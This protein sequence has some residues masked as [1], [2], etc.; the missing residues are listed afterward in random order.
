MISHRHRCLYVKAPKCASTSILQWFLAHGAGR[1]T[2]RPSWYPGPLEHRI[3]PAAEALALYPD[4]VLFTFLRDPC[5]RF[6]STW[7]HA[8]RLVADGAPRQ[9]RGYGSLHDFARLCAELLAETR[10]LWGA[11]ALNFRAEHGRRRYGPHGIE[12]RH[13]YF[14]PCHAR[15]QVDFLP[16]G[17]PPSLF[18][19][20][21]KRPA[22]PAFTGRV[23][24]LDKDFTRLCARLGLAGP[25]LPRENATQRDAEPRMDATTRR[26]VE[27]LYAEDY[28]LLAA[29]PPAPGDAA[30]PRPAGMKAR[31]GRARLGLGAAEIALEAR[32]ARC[33][34]LRRALAPLS[35]LRRSRA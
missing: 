33:A 17:D 26:L 10:G 25:A 19:V 18:G 22:A 6:F 30:A 31:L 27:E 5:A 14:L 28:A 24:T 11:E 16:G 29:P 13:L 35:H 32:L 7:R 1:H 8:Q 20:R 15:P 2:D 4:Y 21:L 9:P 23:E 12:L 3:V 34:S